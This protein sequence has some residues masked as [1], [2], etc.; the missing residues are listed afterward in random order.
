MGR[1]G[2]E[3]APLT[4]S[5][6]PI[7]GGGGAKSDAP[8]APKPPQDADLAAIVKAW[9]DLPEHIKHAIKALVQPHIKV[10]RQ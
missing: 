9:P 8:D 7:S 10:Q 5:I 4:P 2:H 6:T 3:H 1:V